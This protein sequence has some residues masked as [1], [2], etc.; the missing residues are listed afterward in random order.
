MSDLHLIICNVVA[1][2][3]LFLFLWKKKKSNVSQ[4]IVGV[5]AVSSAISLFYFVILSSTSWAVEGIS[6]T[7]LLFL[8]L[9]FTLNVLALSGLKKAESIVCNKKLI[10]FF[11]WFICCICI[12]PFFCNVYYMLFHISNSI[13]TFGE[14]YGEQVEILHG[15]IG[16]LNRYAN[17]LRTFYVV[18]FFYFISQFRSNRVL[19][20]GLLFGILNPTISNLNIGSRFIFV[21]DFLALMAMF[22]LFK[23]TLSNIIRKVIVRFSIIISI[24]FAIVFL[25]IS[26]VKLR[27]STNENAVQTSLALYGGESFLNFS[28]NMWNYCSETNGDNAFFIFKYILGTYPGEHRDS[29]ALTAKSHILAKVF[30]TYIGDFYM[31]FGLEGAFFIVLIISILIVFFVKRANSSNSLYYYC[32]LYIFIRIL[33]SGFTYYPYLNCAWEIVYTPVLLM[34]I[35]IIDAFTRS[36]HNY[37]SA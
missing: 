10:K 35:Q 30:Y 15:V 17:Y 8:F 21:S 16:T 5:W 12:A 9:C 13:T 33:V 29:D 18:L 11:A 14:N 23:E 36:K 3:L 6:I 4:F 19:C 20:L 32:W 28:T 2:I 31:D 34:F 26:V 7:A 27:Y 22:L 37:P 1:Y 24:V 25:S